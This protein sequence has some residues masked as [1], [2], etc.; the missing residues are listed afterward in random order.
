MSLRVY[1]EI[2]LDGPGSRLDVYD[3][4]RQR[5]FDAWYAS[6]RTA[7]RCATVFVQGAAD[8]YGARP[9]RQYAREPWKA[10]YTA[11]YASGAQ[12]RAG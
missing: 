11:G 8:G 10:S 2:D 4:Q 12:T 9:P 1:P 3:P 7:R 5:L 6:E